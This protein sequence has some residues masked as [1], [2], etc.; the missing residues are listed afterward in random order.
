M[1]VVTF[2]EDADVNCS[3]VAPRLRQRG[4]ACGYANHRACANQPFA[5]NAEAALA[6]RVGYRGKSVHRKRQTPVVFA[7]IRNHNI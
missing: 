1:R 4:S 2:L 5:Y 6:A 3:P 7:E